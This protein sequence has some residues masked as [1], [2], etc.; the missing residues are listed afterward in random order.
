MAAD[1]ADLKR[2]DKETLV[3]GIQR[4]AARA[5]KYKEKA[6][7]TAE[8]TMELALAGGTAFGVG[9][10]LGTIERDTP[11]DEVEEALKMFGVDTDLLIGVTLAG[12]GLTGM[13]GKKMSGAA[14]AAGT[15]ALCYWAGNY[16]RK[17]GSTSEEA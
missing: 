12:V 6:K 17:I 13:A 2:L 5:R 4:M 7:E 9:Y 10:Y 1:T 14:R 15:G 3:Q 16:G 11:A 8:Q